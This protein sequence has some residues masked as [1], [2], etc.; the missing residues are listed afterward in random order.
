NVENDDSLCTLQEVFQ[1]VNSSLGFNIELKFDD[2][3]VYQDEELV[4]RLREILRSVEVCKRKTGYFLYVPT[5]CGTAWGTE[6]YTDVRRN[7]LDEAI[8]LCLENGLQGIVSDVRGLLKDQGA[9]SRIKEALLSLL[10]YGEL[11]NVRQAVYVQYLI[12]VEGAIVDF[13]GGI[14]DAVSDLIKPIKEEEE[15]ISFTQSEF[16][17][18]QNLIS[19]LI[20]H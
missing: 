8:K 11:N 17:F 10:T 3:F 18:L 1:N 7:S 9:V 13:V 2:Y 14:S 12:G 20:Q 15:R 19:E 4:D 16:F 6:I 5:R